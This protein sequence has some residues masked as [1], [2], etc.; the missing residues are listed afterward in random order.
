MLT[1]RI[2]EG[3]RRAIDAYCAE[4]GISVTAWV[5]ALGRRVQQLHEGAPRDE[6]LQSVADETVQLARSIDKERRARIPTKG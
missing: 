2:S 4:R 6:V 1:V 3:S 5:E